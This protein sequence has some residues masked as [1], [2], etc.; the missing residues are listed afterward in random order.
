[1]D[2]KEGVRLGMLD[3]VPAATRAAVDPPFERNL[4]SPESAV[5]S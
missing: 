3:S 1:V 2:E 5:K 4:V